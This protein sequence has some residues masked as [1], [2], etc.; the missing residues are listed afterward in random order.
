MDD[1]P[2]LF[3]RRRLHAVRQGDAGAQGLAPAYARMEEDGAW[4]TASR[5]IS[6]ASSRR[7][8]ACSSPPPTPR[9]SPTSSIAAARPAF[10]GC[11]T[12]GP[13]ALSTLPATGNTSR[14]AIS[15]TIPRRHLFLIDYAQRQRDQDLGRGARRRRRRRADRQADA[16]GL[17]GA[18]R[19]GDPVHGC[20]WDA[21]CPQH[22]PQRVRGRG[23]RCRARRAGQSYRGAGERSEAAAPA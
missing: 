9:A 19:A 23:C 22:I 21:N 2:Y 16:G 11:S 15:P 10:C 17:Q 12:T 4:Q 18:A 1:A 7:R 6:R 20:A 8:R 14:R 3:Q 13:S 5:P